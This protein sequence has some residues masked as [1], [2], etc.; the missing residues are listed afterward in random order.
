MQNYELYSK[1]QEALNK[2]EGT[3]NAAAR[4]WIEQAEEA[5]FNDQEANELFSKAKVC[6]VKWRKGSIDGRISKQRMIDCVRSIMEK[7]LPNPYTYVEEKTEK[8]EEHKEEKAA[9]ET[10]EQS[11]IQHLLGVIPEDEKNHFFKAKKRDKR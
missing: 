10:K 7:N 9:I 3:F 2:D 5:N 11:T 6:C 4:N 8:E 1:V